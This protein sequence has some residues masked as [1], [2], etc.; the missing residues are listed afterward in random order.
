MPSSRIP[1][2]GFHK[3]SGQARVYIDAVSIYLGAYDSDESKRKYK[4]VIDQWQER[5]DAAQRRQELKCLP[6]L[7]VGELALLYDQHA[8]TYYV[9][10]GQ[11]TS[12]VH[13]IKAAIRFVTR[14]NSRTAVADFGPKKLKAV[15]EQIVASGKVRTTVN[16]YIEI[17][18]RMFAWGVSEE[19]VP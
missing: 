7:S 5:R 10:D 4:Q 15:R 1:K 16:K 14:S 11:P 17:V 2:Y 13:C 3:P 6:E 9:K 18:R 8:A 19:L 12:E